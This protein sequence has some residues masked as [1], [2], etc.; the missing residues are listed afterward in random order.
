MSVSSLL[1]LADIDECVETPLICGS[2]SACTNLP[3]TFRCHCTAGFKHGEACAGVCV[4]ERTCA[5]H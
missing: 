1:P 3:G 4:C 5:H 2:A